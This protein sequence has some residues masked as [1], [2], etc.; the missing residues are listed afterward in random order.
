METKDKFVLNRDECVDN[1]GIELTAPAVDDEFAALFVAEGL[2][3]YPF[4][5][6]RVGV[7]LKRNWTEGQTVELLGV[8][9]LFGFFNRWN[10]SLATTLEAEPQE[11]AQKHLAASGWQAGKHADD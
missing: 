4:R 2:F 3:V 10:D 8:V 1:I 6:Q 7:E 11:I 5:A 9:C